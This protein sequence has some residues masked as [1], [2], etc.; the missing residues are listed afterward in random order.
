MLSN[1]LLWFNSKG[2][3]G[4][5]TMTASHAVACAQAGWRVLVVDLDPQGNQS[6]L[7]G[8]LGTESDDQ[9]ASLLNAF[10]APGVIEPTVVRDVR[11]GLD[12]IVGGPATAP[13]TQMIG[14]EATYDADKAAAAVQTVLE[15][16]ADN[17]DLI[18]VDLGPSVDSPL[19]RSAMTAARFL[20]FTVAPTKL[21][22]QGLSQA[23]KLTQQVR[24][25]TNPDLEP[26]GLVI[27]KWDKKATKALRKLQDFVTERQQQLGAQFSLIEPLVPSSDT[28]AAQLEESGRVAIEMPSLLKQQK[29][30]KMTWVRAVKKEQKKAEKAAIEA[31]LPPD[32]VNKARASIRKNWL[33]EEP[34]VYTDLLLQIDR[35]HKLITVEVNARWRAAHDRAAYTTHE[36]QG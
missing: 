13:I 31:G 34:E 4:K 16:L 20:V 11:P 7:L 21:S 17:Y 24:K 15:P 29:R 28:A 32:E 30:D 6:V 36:V 5:T 35:A 10:K 3:S 9:G 18:M 2:G 22:M 27:P 12:V 33:T 14:L 8:L 1:L 19:H 26:L 25:T 23:W